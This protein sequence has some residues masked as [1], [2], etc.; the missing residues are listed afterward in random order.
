MKRLNVLV[1]K[2]RGVL[3]E[4]AVLENLKLTLIPQLCLD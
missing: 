1:C 2:W 3:M 4:H